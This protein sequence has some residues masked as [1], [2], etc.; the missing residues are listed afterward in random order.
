M[1]IVR[2]IKN[3]FEDKTNIGEVRVVYTNQDLDKAFFSHAGLLLIAVLIIFSFF[4]LCVFILRRQ[5]TGFFQELKIYFDGVL[6]ETEVSNGKSYFIT[7]FQEVIEFLKLTSRQ[8]AQMRQ[9]EKTQAALTAVGKMASQVAHDIQ[10]PLSTLQIALYDLKGISSDTTELF[11]QSVK[12]ICQIADDLKSVWI[13]K[14]N[15]SEIVN[16]TILLSIQKIVREKQS[17]FM[18]KKKISIDFEA[19]EDGAHLVEG[20][21]SSDLER[22]LSNLLNNSFESMNENG[23][24]R[25]VAL[26][27]KKFFTIFV[28]DDGCGIASTNLSKVF[29]FGYTSGKINGTGLGLFHAKEIITACGGQIFIE[30]QEKKGTRIKIVLPL[31]KSSQESSISRQQLL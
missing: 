18:Q 3:H 2:A 19:P 30:S 13:G 27:N 23:E 12:R 25:I 5:L 14:Q 16:D 26:K 1:E 9:K 11:R 6:N 31:F 7:D 10:S 15:V 29:E 21:R 28:E 17:E 22:V 4:V 24:I 20:L 8:I